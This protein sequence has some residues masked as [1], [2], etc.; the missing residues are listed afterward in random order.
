MRIEYNNYHLIELFKEKYFLESLDKS[1]EIII[2]ILEQD[3]FDKVNQIK[4]Q[5]DEEKQIFLKEML[6]LT[7]N[8]RKIILED[9]LRNVNFE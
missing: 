3:F 4:W 1:K 6:A 9:V 7:P 2:T 8:D 5:D